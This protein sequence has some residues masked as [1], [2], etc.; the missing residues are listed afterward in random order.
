MCTH[1]L[2]PD[3][4]EL[5]SEHPINKSPVQISLRIVS[6]IAFGDHHYIQFYNTLM[7]TC[8]RYLQLQLVGRDMY[9]P[10]AK[11]S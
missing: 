6:D 2:K 5:C 1:A 3:P 9:D 11:V 10:A 4:M 8:L 7:R